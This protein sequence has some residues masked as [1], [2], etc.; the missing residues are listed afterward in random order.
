MALI[1]CPD[2][3]KDIS[4]KAAECLNCGRP[5]HGALGLTPHD[6]AVEI[7]QTYS[8]IIRRIGGDI[9]SARKS[10]VRDYKETMRNL[11]LTN[12]AVAA[13]SLPLLSSPEILRIPLI[14]GIVLL[15]INIIIAYAHLQR[16]WTNAFKTF[17]KNEKVKK[18]AGRHLCNFK[19]KTFCVKRKLTIYPLLKI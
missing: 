14:F 12:A 1:K 17:I 16:G 9:N 3:G 2:C 11:I 7:H 18:N 5:I 4:N 15:L 8:K 19:R 10:E 6:V 13:F